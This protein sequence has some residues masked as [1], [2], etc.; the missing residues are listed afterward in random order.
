[1]SDIL[2]LDVLR[3]PEKLIKIGGKTVN[4]GFIPTGITWDIESIQQKAAKLD[5]KKLAAGGEETKKGLDLTIELCS[6]FCKVKHPDMTP[7]W[8]RD[9]TDVKQI[10][11]LADEINKTLAKALEDIGQYSKNEEAGSQ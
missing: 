11:L 3:P 4:V 6:A 8:F 2:D 1:M 9:N 10:R 5:Q 7:D